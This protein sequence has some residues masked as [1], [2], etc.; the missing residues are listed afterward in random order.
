M[1]GDAHAPV[2]NAQP[3]HVVPP[4]GDDATDQPLPVHHGVCLT[5]GVALE[6]GAG[7]SAPGA[8]E[9]VISLA[10]LPS[11]AMPHDRGM[12]RRVVI[13]VFDG[14]QVLDLT[15][16]MEVFSAASRGAG[17]GDGYATEVVST[18]GGTARS[19]C[20]LVVSV[21]RRL[22]ACRG[23]IDTLVVVG[24]DGTAAAV[25]DAALVAWVR[26]AAGAHA[27]GHVGVLGCLRAGAGRAARRKAG[28]D[29]LVAVRPPGGCVPRRARERDPI[30]VQDGSV[31]TS[32]GVTAGMDLSLRLV[33]DDHG[34][35][36][37]RAV[38]RRLVLFVQ[39]PGGQ[40]QFSVQLASQPAARAPL[41]ELEA[42]I[43]RPPR[44]G[45]FP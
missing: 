34:A 10:L 17:A 1:V 27:A 26:A 13:V 20:G 29:T 33:E 12:P 18:P 24:G 36:A 5:D 15:G 31:W 41:R 7:R 28:Y 40:A 3:A 14:F 45:T 8:A 38:A 32:A 2:D 4:H 39:R 37:A 11:G 9:I 6:K 43:P 16:P 22:S 19:S 35:D 23:P 30:F 44:R 21:D 42:W 25:H